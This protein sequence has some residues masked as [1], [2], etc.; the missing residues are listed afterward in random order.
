MGRHSI[1][2]QHCVSPGKLAP[3]RV[4][5]LLNTDGDNLGGDTVDG[6]EIKGYE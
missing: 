1:Y 2:V 3:W 6:D 4:T 5:Q